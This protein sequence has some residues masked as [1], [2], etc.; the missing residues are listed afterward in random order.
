V[1]SAPSAPAARPA[2]PRSALRAALGWAAGWAAT[3]GAFALALS[4]GIAQR[5]GVAAAE[6]PALTGFWLVLYLLVALPAALVGAAIL[7]ATRA[8]RLDGTR[9]LVLGGVA[10][11]GLI[12]ALNLVAAWPVAYRIL[13]TL[14]RLHVPL[15]L[16]DLVGV[17]VGYAALLVG[18]ERISRPRAEGRR[19][20]VRWLAASL[21]GLALLHGFNWIQERPT[22]IDVAARVAPQVETDPL[23]RPEP[24]P[25]RGVVV[26]AL[27]GFTWTVAAPMM[28]RELLPNLTRLLGRSSYGLLDIPFPS[29]SPVVWASMATGLP[30]ER[31]GVH[32]HL[33]TRIPG[34]S[35]W[36]SWAPSL[37]SFT[38]WGAA[39]K[40]LALTTDLGISHAERIPSST[41]SGMA[42]WDVAGANGHTVGVY[43][44]MQTWPVEPVN[45]YMYT[46]RG[47]PPLEA[48]PREEVLAAL[49]RTPAPDPPPRR[50]LHEPYA[51]E[52]SEALALFEHFH[53]SVMLHL[54]KITD[55]AH[56]Y[57]V[58]LHD[59]LTFSS[60]PRPWNHFNAVVESAYAYADEWI[61]RFVA[62]LPE[63]FA[64]AIVSDHGYEFD[65]DHHA[66]M[67]PGVI[68]L[69]GGPF[70]CN[71]VLEGANVLDVAPT[72]LAALG[73][74]GLEAM[75]GSVL[76][77]AFAEGMAPELERW[78]E[79]PTAWRQPQ[80]EADPGTEEEL[81]ELRER[82]RALGYLN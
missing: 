67:P 60:L 14:P 58:S 70:A 49:A 17:A 80:P 26:L 78:P 38:W 82:L 27:D 66:F 65:G 51:K 20:G 59:R 22:R 77:R 15:G 3:A 54:N 62:A 6:L 41:R 44:W 19:A 37:N 72:L 31:H 5:N 8:R 33:R 46:L 50:P 71:R 40:L 69:A 57:W 30:N 13:S 43:D 35:P 32:G 2:P 74:P 56:D 11:G 47:R 81:L 21:L 34:V 9:G 64:I 55:H 16:F 1:S 76:E 79:Y 63:G 36:I 73:L 23:C 29:Y 53:P 25:L 75:P 68:V 52:F 39:N 42:I 28:E 61:A 10:A 7:V 18:A 45:G 4:I 12:L 24:G 48:Y